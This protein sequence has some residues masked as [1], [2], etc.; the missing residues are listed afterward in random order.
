MKVKSNKN[1]YV[2]TLRGVA[3]VL[4]VMGHVIGSASDG[5]MKVAD[6]SFLRY[7]YYTFE[8][9]RMPLFTVISGWVYAL[10][11][12]AVDNLVQFMV[13]KARRILVPMIFVGGL[14]YI[15]QSLVPGTN[16][17]NSLEDIWRITIF[18]YTFYWYLHSLFLV[19]L[20]VA[21]MDSC[22]IMDSFRGLLLVALVSI[23]FLVYRDTLIMEAF[24]NYF[25]FKGAIYLLPFFVI[26]V[27]I[28]RFKSV[29]KNKTLGGLMALVLLGSLVVQQLAW[30]G[31]VPYRF[32]ETTGLGLVIGLLGTVVLFRSKF[33]VPSMVWIGNYAYTIF[34]F[35]SFGTSGGRIIL[36]KL[37][38]NHA[39]VIFFFSLMLGLLLPVVVEKVF[40]RFNIT[41]LL[42]LGRPLRRQEVNLKLDKQFS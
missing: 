12:A 21:L 35:H 1:P 2:E 17:S 7:L 9:L 4:V 27:G 16:Y 23:L 20:V 25:G 15:V 42:F 38:V 26:G 31:L 8:Y 14:Y 22:K 40:N 39:P 32:S 19:F 41:R 6:D 30:F 5:G 37:G 28:Q 34:L 33:K 24:P 36:Q 3:I 18:P 11:P 10:R 13:K 29:F